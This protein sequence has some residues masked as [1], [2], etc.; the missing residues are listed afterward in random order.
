MKTS[1]LTF[2]VK[3]SYNM[4]SILEVYIKII[5]SLLFLSIFLVL[6][7][8]IEIYLHIPHYFCKIYVERV[9]ITMSLL[10]VIYHMCTLI[11]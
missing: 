9:V 3:I 8:S 2:M 7:I 10:F 4:T 6:Q 11:Y 1:L 5:F